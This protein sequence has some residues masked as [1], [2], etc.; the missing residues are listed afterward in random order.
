MWRAA[1][2]SGKMGCVEVETVMD[3]TSRLIVHPA[4]LKLRAGTAR[5][6]D[7]GDPQ[8]VRIDAS[9]DEKGRG[10]VST[11]DDRARDIDRVR[12]AVIDE[13]KV[14]LASAT[15]GT[16]PMRRCAL[17]LADALPADLRVR[18]QGLHLGPSDP[19]L[20]SPAT[21]PVLPVARARL[22]RRPRPR[23]RR[24][25]DRGSRR[26][27]HRDQ[28]LPGVRSAGLRRDRCQRELRRGAARGHD[29][30]RGLPLPQSTGASR[31]AG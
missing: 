9:G 6:R 2:P 14:H 17:A 25:G 31:S 10:R 12:T 20:G 26:G 29:D 27:D 21:E 28:P 18:C 24:R 11:G 16:C 22:V 13:L 23:A 5:R 3:V 1:R 15:R 7:R 4:S 30:R 8:R 19:R